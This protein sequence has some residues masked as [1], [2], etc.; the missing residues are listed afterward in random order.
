MSARS[1][2]AVLFTDNDEEIIQRIK[3][4]DI[5]K[6][7][8]FAVGLLIVGFLLLQTSIGVRLVGIRWS[9]VILCM[10][11]ILMLAGISRLVILRHYRII[12][13]QQQER[14]ERQR[15]REEKAPHT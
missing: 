11:F 9:T 1:K 3:R 15:V 13:R 2:F 7:K 8:R 12:L 5:P 14:E 4:T 10:G 6:Q